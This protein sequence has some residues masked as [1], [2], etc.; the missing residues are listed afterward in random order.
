MDHSPEHC[1]VAVEDGDVE[2]KADADESGAADAG[3]FARRRSWKLMTSYV[4]DI[5]EVQF[6][7]MISKL[8]TSQA[9]ARYQRPQAEG[10]SG[11]RRLKRQL[12]CCLE[13]WDRIPAIRRIFVFSAHSWA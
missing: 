9:L 12:H 4:F 3:R 11:I 7:I 1:R 6:L 13:D 5:T 8:M 10:P 2:L